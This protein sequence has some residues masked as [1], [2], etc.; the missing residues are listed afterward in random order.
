[1]ARAER[2]QAEERGSRM[3]AAAIAA[4][5]VVAALLSGLSARGHADSPPL[6]PPAPVLA[7]FDGGQI[8]VADFEAAVANKAPVLRVAFKQQAERERMLRAMVDYELLIREATRRGYA[9]DDDVHAAM[10][11]ELT[12]RI[13][14]AADASVDEATLPEPDLR[15]YYDAH[16]AQLAIPAM[17][18]AT[19]IRVATRQEATELAARVRRM[20]V[21]DFR[22]LALGR[23]GAGQGHGSELPYVDA[24]G[25]PAGVPSAAPVDRALVERAFALA[26]EG[27]VSEPFEHG[28]GFVVLQLTGTTTG[29]GTRFEDAVPRVHEALAL[30]RRAQARAALEQQLR[31]AYVVEVH[32]ELSEAIA[33]DPVPP[34]DIPAGFPAAPPDPRA[35]TVTVEPDGA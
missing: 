34:A 19:Y 22:D 35:A 14:A 8:T 27:Q 13:E 3:A 5:V 1:M 17:R 15:A 21:S 28:G 4:A 24:E 30:E 29:A 23:G 26:K 18:R 12:H 6:P 9:N 2:G 11:I 10:L 20:P 32:A 31:G 7:S 16:R 25:H 33:L